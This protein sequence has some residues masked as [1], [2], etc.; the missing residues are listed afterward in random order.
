MNLLCLS[1]FN[2]GDIA[3]HRGEL[4]WFP[5]GVA[6]RLMDSW[7]GCWAVAPIVTVEEVVETE[8]IDA[9]PVDKMMHAPAKAKAHAKAAR[10]KG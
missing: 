4:C 3:A 6:H 10:H 9:P 1:D 7:P 5:L 2:Q 8:A